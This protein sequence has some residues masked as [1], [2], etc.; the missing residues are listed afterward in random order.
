MTRR[1]LFVIVILVATAIA[2]RSGFWVLHA[3]SGLANARTLAE[4]NLWSNAYSELQRYLRLY[5][6]DATARLLIAEALIK[7][8]TRGREAVHEALDH[9]SHIPDESPHGAQARTH[10]GRLQL[11]IL[12]QPER[13]QKSLQRALQLDSDYFEAHYLTWKLLDLTGRS[14][15]AEANFWKCYELSPA[16][17]RA[18]RLREWY[19]SQFYPNTA[20]PALDATMGFVNTA[21]EMNIETEL[22]R[23]L[24]FR[25]AEP[26]APLVYAALA[27]WFYKD[28]DPQHAMRVLEVSS[29]LDTAL[30]NPYFVCTL[31]GALFDLG[32]FDEAVA[33]FE[34]W[35]GPRQGYEYWK[36]RATISDE[37]RGDYPDAIEFY[38]KALGIWPGCAEWRL[39]S[40]KAN[41]LLRMG[42]QKEAQE[43]RSASKVIEGLMDE[44]VHS[45]LRQHLGQLDS[46]D[47]LE[48]VAEF[49]A[50]IGREKESKAWRQ[51]IQRLQTMSG[52][53]TPTGLLH[54]TN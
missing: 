38:D 12:H 1:F 41:C 54:V 17:E 6:E 34:R 20:N 15:L 14:H 4:L 30:D 9:L 42:R 29:S 52:T 31:V 24:G 21:R 7:D 50:K 28:G 25:N 2:L 5:P 44:T 45:K 49:Y 26:E 32:R 37:V 33:H 51:E 23:L 35:P 36:W 46:L 18:V 16:P 3:H 13:A 22:A 11:L 10:Q 19:M 53:S 39:L 40:R 27:H 47:G 43:V 8:E 48:E